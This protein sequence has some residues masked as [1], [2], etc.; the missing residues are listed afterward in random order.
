[1]IREVELDAKQYGDARRTLIAAAARTVA[2]VRIVQEP[3]TVIVSEKGWV[4]ARQGHGHDASMMSFKTGDGFYGAFEVLTTDHLFALGS[5]GRVYSVP[6]ASL[7]SARGDGVPITTLID[8]ETGSR[9]EHWVAAPGPVR[10]LLNTHGGLGLVCQA[11]DLISRNKSGR[12]FLALEP[13]DA[14]SRPVVLPP[15]AQ[16][17]AC[18]TS[19]DAPR[20]LVFGTDELK[21]LKNGGRGTSLMALAPGETLSQALPLG[22]EA[23]TVTGQGR[24]GKAMSR[25]IN[26][27][28]LAEYRG[29][30]GRQGKILEPRWREVLI[31]L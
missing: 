31:G 29:R 7:P 5:N 28:E 25:V 22:V 16:H 27:R 18:L 20:L 12:Q 13:G 30:R 17:L 8:V 11:S 4:R 21:T 24:G 6:V 10:L 2:E 14:P 26:A 1:V 23:L 15:D 9:V 3:V 19:G